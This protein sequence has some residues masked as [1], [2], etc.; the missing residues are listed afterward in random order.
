MERLPP[1]TSL[2]MTLFRPFW[3]RMHTSIY[4]FVCDNSLIH[5]S[6]AMAQRPVI[7]LFKTL[8]QLPQS[9][10]IS[11]VE[12][13]NSHDE[14]E[15]LRYPPFVK[16]FPVTTVSRLLVQQSELLARLQSNLGYTQAT[17]ERLVLPVVTRYAAFVHH[18][19]ASESHHHRG[20]GGL[21]HHGLEVAC[22]AAQ[23]SEGV[24]FPLPN[25]PSERQRAEPL[26]RLA[27]AL[28]G[29]L[30]DVGKPLSDIRVTDR[31]GKISWDPYLESLVAWGERQSLTRY[32]IHW[33][34]QRYQRHQQFSLLALP[35][36]LPR[37][38]LQALATVGP[39]LLQELLE[40]VSG[41][42]N[43]LIGQLVAKADQESVARDLQQSR[44]A[45]EA[46]AYGVP[47]ERYLFDGMRRLHRSGAWVVN[48]PGSPLWQLEWGTFIAWSDAVRVLLPLLSQDG[49]AGIPRDADT[50]ADILLERGLAQPYQIDALP[51]NRYWPVWLPMT[52]SG[53]R[54]DKK[55]LLLKLAHSSL[56]FTGTLPAPLMGAQIGQTSS[57]VSNSSGDKVIA[58]ESIKAAPEESFSVIAA[59]E[60]PESMLH[61]QACD[62]LSQMINDAGEAT[63][64]LA[65]ALTSLL[66][67]QGLGPVIQ[68]LGKQFVIPYP[69]GA[70]Q[71]GVASTV[72]QLLQAG[73]IRLDAILPGRKV[74]IIEGQKVLLF[75]PNW[76]TAINA[77]YKTLP[78]QPIQAIS[79]ETLSLADNPKDNSPVEA[80]SLQT[81][82]DR[83][84][85]GLSCEQ[86]ILSALQ[87]LK[88]QIQQGQGRWLAAPVTVARG[89]WCTRDQ[90]LDRLLQDHPG[91]FD[92]NYL[93][94]HIN[95]NR[96]RPLL[97]WQAGNLYLQQGEAADV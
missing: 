90:A 97:R 4:R 3:S 56:L 66:Q 57:A 32:F 92:K 48:Q 53:V 88:Q 51:S 58:P 39:E 5:S 95:L 79:S 7:R 67:G 42:G 74:H 62:S 13:S 1:W 81:T 52:Q 61:Q 10:D 16:G 29:L 38:C 54:V 73:A 70:A 96:K 25:I 84:L 20:A 2:F 91:R 82:P 21:L 65:M 69:E 59:S 22:W 50:L 27:T 47:V 63:E 33:R 44:L 60:A 19:P 75:S 45:G 76:I 30:H 15:L 9:G 94:Y 31:E 64:A 78:S 93:I 24:I 77:V 80:L 6:V 26:W 40:A 18:L 28:A 68:K 46:A 34:E 85:E 83:S 37:A 89:E 55:W 8:K 35:Q 41:I 12:Q 49:V 72:M 23:S 14:E 36:M 71:L 86:T 87:Q 11:A 43:S 17:F